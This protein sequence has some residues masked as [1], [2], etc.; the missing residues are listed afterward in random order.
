MSESN[1]ESGIWRPNAIQA[2]RSTALHGLGALCQ[3]KLLDGQAYARRGNAAGR[4]R[5]YTG[6]SHLTV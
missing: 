3:V 2:T 5:R 4:R 6:S 1:A